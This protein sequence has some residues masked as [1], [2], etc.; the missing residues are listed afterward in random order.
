MSNRNIYEDLGGDAIFRQLVERFYQRVEHDPRLRPMFPEDMEP[1]KEHQFLFL[2]QYFGG[3][4]RYQAVR[5]HPRLRMRH[6][7]FPIGQQERDAWLEHMLAAIDEV[8]IPEPARS[9]MRT[10]FEQAATAMV[11]RVIP[12]SSRSGRASA[13]SPNPRGRDALLRHPRILAV[14]T[15]F[16][17]SVFP[18]APVAWLIEQFPA[19]TPAG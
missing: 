14:G 16:C 18:A 1:G 6:N 13:S 11:N 15:R 19:H 2:T 8:G 5:G 3:P 12:E 9:V 7:P 17:A 4:P 10:Y